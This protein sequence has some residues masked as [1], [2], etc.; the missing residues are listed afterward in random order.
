VKLL[1]ASASPRR[2][3][4]LAGLGLR[5]TVRPADVVETP[6][7]GEAAGD[8]VLRVARDKAAVAGE[9][10]TPGTLV[11]AA[12]TEVV[13]DGEILGKPR[14]AEDAARMLRRLAGREHEVLTGLALAEPASGRE[15][16]HVE[17]SRVRF[18]P[19]IDAEIAW[20]VASGEPMDK[21]GAYAVQGLG[22]LFVEA[23]IGSHSNVVGLPVHALYRLCGAL[24]VDLK[25]LR[26]G[27]PG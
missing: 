13:I 14:D 15:A 9:S 20:Y 3:E 16:A 2:R 4:I 22:A 10:A 8:Y 12:D 19:M 26:T 25:A 1:L 7:P 11:L 18:A 5:F 24:G 27:S 21:A 6:E 23:V 17:I